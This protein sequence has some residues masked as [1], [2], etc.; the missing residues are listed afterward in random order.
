M[1]SGQVHEVESAEQFSELIQPQQN[2][3]FAATIVDFTASW[4]PPC[5]AIKPVF[6]EMATHY[7]DIQFLKVDVDELKV[8]ARDA[9][10]YAM[11]TFIIYRGGERTNESIRGADKEALRALLESVSSVK[12]SDESG[13][14]S[15]AHN[16]NNQGGNG[17]DADNDDT[18]DLA[19]TKKKRKSCCVI[20]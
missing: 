17:N 5:R 9:K 2:S 13:Q 18:A 4:C 1:A 12:G 8:V 19:K 7:T 6:E 14:K 3:G 15:Q 16:N 10:I 11:P 20:C